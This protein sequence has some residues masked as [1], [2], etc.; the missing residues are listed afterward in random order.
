MNWRDETLCRILL[1]VARII[2]PT[3]KEEIVKLRNHIAYPDD[4]TAGKK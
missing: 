3:W 4:T 1:L 2:N